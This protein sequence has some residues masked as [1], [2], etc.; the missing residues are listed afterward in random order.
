MASVSDHKETE[1]YLEWF[2]IDSEG[3]RTRTDKKLAK[4]LV[5][6]GHSVKYINDI[7]AGNAATDVNDDRKK[8]IVGDNVM[9]LENNIAY[10]DWKGDEDFTVANAAI[11][12]GKKYVS[13]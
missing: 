13:E 4:D 8:A 3:K 2:S 11:V 12:A 10:K 9:S 5:T 1:P 7:I 6:M